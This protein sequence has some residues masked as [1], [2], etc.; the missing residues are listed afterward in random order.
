ML[1]LVGVDHGPNRLHHAV[2]DVEREDA[3]HPAFGVVGYRPRLAVDHGRLDVDTL[4]VRAAEQPE[5]EPGDTLGPV[6][7]LAP[8]LGLAAA[9]AHHDH[10]GGEKLEQA[11]EV[12]AVDRVEE[13]ARHLIALR[14]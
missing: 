5:Q 8:G 2:G 3:D 14:A 9:V 7:R 1:E 10:I 11:V 13:A 12:A 6:Q 4:L